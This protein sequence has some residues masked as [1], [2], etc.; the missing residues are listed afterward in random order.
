[1]LVGLEQFLDASPRDL[2]TPGQDV[3]IHAMK[4]GDAVSDPF[5]DLGRLDAGREP[6]GYARVPIMENSP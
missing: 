4:N 5:G 1:M 2:A 3:C 6:G